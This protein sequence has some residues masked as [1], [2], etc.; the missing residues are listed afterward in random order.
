VNVVVAGASGA[1]G[2]AALPALRAAGHS[3]TGITTRRPA[4]RVIEA[5]GATAVV[6]D[7][8]DETQLARLARGADA[9]VHLAT[10]IPPIALM[11]DRRAWAENDR[12]RTVGARRLVDAALSAGVGLFVLESVTFL[13]PDRGDTW[14]DESVPIGDVPSFARSAVEAER[15]AT[16][17]IAAGGRAVVLRFGSLY[18]PDAPS[19]RETAELVRRRRFPVVGSGR[20]YYSSLHT[21][22]AGKAIAAALVVASGV[23]NVSDDEPLRLGEYASLLAGLFDAPTPLRLPIWATRVLAGEPVRLLSESRRIANA[24]FRGASGWAPTYPSAREGWR[25]VRDA[26]TDVRGTVAS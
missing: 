12:L 22:D 5:L 25:A 23:Y 21:L 8:E 20:A 14:I 19:S 24:R 7:I 9:I 1:L 16:G 26:W 10:R 18:G 6:A 11:R 15:E 17:F 13:Y 4:I 2:R 3:V